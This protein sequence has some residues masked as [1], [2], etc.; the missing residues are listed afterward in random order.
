[1]TPSQAPGPEPSETA[2]GTQ[3]AAAD[4]IAVTTL[5]DGTGGEPLTILV[6]FAPGATFGEELHHT[7][8]IL[9]VIEGKFRDGE[10]VHPAR[11]LVTANEGSVH[12]PQPR[13]G[14]RVLV[15]RSTGRA[16]DPPGVAP[17]RRASRCLPG[18]T[19]CSEP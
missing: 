3:D 4:D 11:T 18:G 9:Y 13:T 7:K 10:R 8:E 6:E 5:Q 2:P 15:P 16:P 17:S 19:R 12:R 1:M 14:C